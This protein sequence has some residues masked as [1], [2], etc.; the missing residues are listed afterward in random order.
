MSVSLNI[1]GKPSDTPGVF[2]VGTI[3]KTMQKIYDRLKNVKRDE[4]I[5]ACAGFLVGAVS[6]AWFLSRPGPSWILEQLPVANPSPF[7]VSHS[8]SDFSMNERSYTVNPLFTPQI[9]WSTLVRQANSSDFVRQD[10]D[11][12]P[13]SPLTINSSVPELNVNRMVEVAE[14]IFSAQVSSSN[15]TLEDNSTSILTS[16]SIIA[17]SLSSPVSSS[18]QANNTVKDGSSEINEVNYGSFALNLLTVL[19]G[20]LYYKRETF[21]THDSFEISCTSPSPSK[22]D[23]ETTPNSLSSRKRIYSSKKMHSLTMSAF[24][25]VARDV[26]RDL[27]SLLMGTPLR[28]DDPLRDSDSVAVS[29]DFDGIVVEGTGNPLPEV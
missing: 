4:A 18:S 28:V 1:A 2:S 17:S 8:V 9:C 3:P 22:K 21:L 20:L 5:V 19:S 29:L 24:H 14:R 7:R 13:S 16:K 26:D 11:V 27:A 15:L 25:E 10:N 12:L 6:T 23:T